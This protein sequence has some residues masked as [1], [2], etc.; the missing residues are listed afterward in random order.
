MKQ[1]CSRVLSEK[2]DLTDLSIRKVLA[3]Y[4]IDVAG[5]CQQASFTRQARRNLPFH[6]FVGSN[7]FYKIVT[8][9]ITLYQACL[10]D[11]DITSVQSIPSVCNLFVTEYLPEKCKMF[12]KQTAIDL[13]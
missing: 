7:Q 12:P 4:L 3:L 2:E 1:E 13:T 6:V 9:F 8:A 5:V 10:H 11:N